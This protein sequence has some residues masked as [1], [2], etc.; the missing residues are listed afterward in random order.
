MVRRRPAEERVRRV[1][2]SITL[3]KELYDFLESMI[4]RK[5]FKDRTHVINAALDYLKWTI[6]NKPM[7]YFGPRKLSNKPPSPQP[8]A[9]KDPRYPR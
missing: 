8:A 6:E 4:D 9:N 2:I 7:D 3:D 5:M 1:P